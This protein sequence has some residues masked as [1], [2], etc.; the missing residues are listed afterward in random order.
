LRVRWLLR[1]CFREVRVSSP[2]RG[3][4]VA[5]VAVAAALRLRVTRKGS[6]RLEHSPRK[7]QWV[8][9]CISP[10]LRAPRGGSGCAVRRLEQNQN[11]FKKNPLYMRKYRLVVKCY[12]PTSMNAAVRDGRE[13]PA[14][15]HKAL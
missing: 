3:P 13:R 4:R 11:K 14:T 2:W 15:S 10:L 1:A 9:V 5:A 8:R 7:R 12:E 6:G